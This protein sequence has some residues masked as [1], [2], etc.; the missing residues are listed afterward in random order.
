MLYYRRCLH[1]RSSD[2]ADISEISG[3]LG[4]DEM[5]S[6]CDKL[7]ILLVAA[8]KSR[9]GARVVFAV[10][11]DGPRGRRR[12]EIF[13]PARRSKP[14]VHQGAWMFN[15]FTQRCREFVRAA[16]R[17]VGEELACTILR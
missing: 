11:P 4:D 1:S 3:A 13:G 17:N 10:D 14:I 9:Y 7:Q 2:A 15:S 5:G 12:T 16:R 8:K 6:R